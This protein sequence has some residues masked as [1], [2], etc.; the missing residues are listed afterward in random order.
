MA[1]ALLRVG[2]EERPLIQKKPKVWCLPGDEEVIRFF[3]P[4]PYKRG[5]GFV[6][7]GFVGIELPRLRTWLASYD[8]GQPSIFHHSFVAH[9]TLNDNDREQFMVDFENEPPADRLAELLYDKLTR[10]PPSVE[11]LVSTYRQDPA[12]LGGL[13][14]PIHSAAWELLL[15]W[16]ETPDDKLRVPRRGL[17]GRIV[18]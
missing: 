14:G 8:D 16:A 7:T 13:A 6:Y 15:R 2:L 1:G 11:K 18:V 12:S 3:Q 9:H 5:W 4:A 17:D 10:I